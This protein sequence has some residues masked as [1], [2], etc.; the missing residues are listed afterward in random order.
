MLFVPCVRRMIGGD[1]IEA[2]IE[3]RFQKF[4]FVA[5]SFDGR[6]A[7]DQCS[8]AGVAIA[9]KPKVVHTNFS[10]NFLFVEGDRIGEERQLFFSRNVKDMESGFKIFCERNCELRRLKKLLFILNYRMK[11]KLDSIT[12]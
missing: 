3:Q 9:V 11:I 5:R 7:F 12:I 10:S 4:L 8:E 2:I 1:N 6:I